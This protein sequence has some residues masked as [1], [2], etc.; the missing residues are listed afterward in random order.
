MPCIRR[1]SGPEVRPGRRP[2]QQ[3]AERIQRDVLAG[4]EF[5]EQISHPPVR[6]AGGYIAEEFRRRLAELP[7]DEVVHGEASHDVSVITAGTDYLANSQGQEGITKQRD[8]TLAESRCH[9]TRPVAPEGDAVPAG[10]A[11]EKIGGN[12]VTGQFEDLLGVRVSVS[13]DLCKVGR[14]AFIIVA[15]APCGQ[16]RSPRAM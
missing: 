12:S 9:M 8:R 10:Q 11:A 15:T 3:P 16:T 14:H 5:A 2:D 1:W 7:G 13:R 6:Q 4:T